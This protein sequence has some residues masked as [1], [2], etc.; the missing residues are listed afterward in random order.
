LQTSLH[1]N[2]GKVVDI[3]ALDKEV[4]FSALLIVDYFYDKSDYSNLNI[5]SQYEKYIPLSPEEDYINIYNQKNTE[6]DI[7]CYMKR[8]DEYFYN[9]NNPISKIIYLYIINQRL[10]LSRFIFL[11]KERIGPI[12][13]A[14]IYFYKHSLISGRFFEFMRNLFNT[15]SDLLSDDEKKY[16]ID[17][18]I[19][20]YLEKDLSVSG[21]GYSRNSGLIDLIIKMFGPDYLKYNILLYTIKSASFAPNKSSLL[22]GI[23]SSIN[24]NKLILLSQEDEIK[25]TYQYNELKKYISDTQ[26]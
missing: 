4:L 24:K 11:N 21:N 7:Y 17:N 18:I 15:L 19:F 1:E 22:L 23:Y 2:P 14:F 6:V 16:F 12:K 20:P 25:D 3:T 13:D 5:L 9:S 8:A 26:K 10:Y